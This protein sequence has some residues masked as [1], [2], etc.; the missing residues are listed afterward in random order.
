MIVEKI[1]GSK[2]NLKWKQ[3]M[4]LRN[5]LIRVERMS[6]IYPDKEVKG[7]WFMTVRY[8]RIVRKKLKTGGKRPRIKKEDNQ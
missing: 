4:L 5:P 3:K 8:Q 7:K 2:K 6:G 1:S